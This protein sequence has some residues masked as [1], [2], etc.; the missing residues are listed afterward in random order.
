VAAAALLCLL[1]TFAERIFHRLSGQEPQIVWALA[2]GLAA[3]GLLVWPR[4][5]I[6]R[7]ALFVLLL[8]MSQLRAYPSRPVASPTSSD[9]YH[10]VLQGM[11]AVHNVDPT[12]KVYF[13]FDAQETNAD[14]YVSLACTYNWGYRLIN[15]RFPALSPDDVEVRQ[16]IWS[17]F[18]LKPTRG[19][20][21]ALLSEKD[22][23]LERANRSL[24]RVGWAAQ[25]LASSVVQQAK[26]H[27][28]MTF[29]EIVPWT[30][31]D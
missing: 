15:T 14:A 28:T 20:K 24:H 5:G 12:S 30:E 1:P 23:A 31:G 21:V 6:A 17:R 16:E 2:P 25:P 7:S 4:P 19:M 10:A 11:Q 27:Y 26:I 8:V 9:S 18:A 13:W 3:L 29:V 22:D